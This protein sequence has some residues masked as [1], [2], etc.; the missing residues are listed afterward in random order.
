MTGLKEGRGEVIASVF[1]CHSLN[2]PEHKCSKLELAEER[3]ERGSP[4]SD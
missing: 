3:E 2:V 4:L 1:F